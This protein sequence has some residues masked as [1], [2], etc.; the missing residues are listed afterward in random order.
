[1][2][3]HSSKEW[4]FS[5]S[6]HT[7]KTSLPKEW[8]SLKTSEIAIVWASVLYS[9]HIFKKRHHCRQFLNSE[10]FNLF[11]SNLLFFF[12]FFWWFCAPCAVK[13]WRGWRF[14]EWNIHSFTF[15]SM[16]SS[17]VNTIFHISLWYVISYARVNFNTLIFLT[18]ARHNCPQYFRYILKRVFYKMPYK[19]KIIYNIYNCIAVFI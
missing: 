6:L 17:Q 10:T 18:K 7:S 2:K 16:L 14:E 12:F 5:S 9:D 19:L 11:K 4:T 8:S 15:D 1:M 3:V 13:F